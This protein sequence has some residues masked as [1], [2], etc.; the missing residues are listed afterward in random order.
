MADVARGLAMRQ[1]MKTEREETIEAQEAYWS[2]A[3]GESGWRHLPLRDKQQHASVVKF[4]PRQ[5]AQIKG[6]SEKRQM[7]IQALIRS[8]LIEALEQDAQAEL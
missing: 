7:S 6:L 4:T 1:G 2:G 3:S 5:W 8:Y